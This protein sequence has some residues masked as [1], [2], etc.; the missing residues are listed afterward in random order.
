MLCDELNLIILY[1]VLTNGEARRTGSNWKKRG[2]SI[3]VLKLRREEEERET[4]V[5]SGRSS[6]GPIASVYRARPVYGWSVEIVAGRISD[7]CP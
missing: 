5:Q 1:V 3:E 2:S 6:Y 7:P 4:F